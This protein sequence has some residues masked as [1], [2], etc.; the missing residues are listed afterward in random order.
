MNKY[1][2]QY[3]IWQYHRNVIYYAR[4]ACLRKVTKYIVWFLNN[5]WKIASYNF[6][7]DIIRSDRCIFELPGIL[8][9]AISEYLRQSW[10]D[11]ESLI[12]ELLYLLTPVYNAFKLR[13]LIKPAFS[14]LKDISHSYIIIFAIFFPI[15]T[16]TGVLRKLAIMC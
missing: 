10:W 3:L 6:V 5:D 12:R 7:I 14:I 8:F 2:Y 4:F 11:Q 16:C 9:E 15:E 1:N 13:W